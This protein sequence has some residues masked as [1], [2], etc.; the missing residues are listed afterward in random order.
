MSR[1]LD[2]RLFYYAAG[3]C[4]VWFAFGTADLFSQSGSSAAPHSPNPSMQVV[5]STNVNGVQ[6]L[7]VLDQNTRGLA[8]YH[9]DA[10]GNLQLRSVRTLVWDLRMEEFNAQA[11]TPSELKRIQP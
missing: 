4:L 3:A 9:V 6:Q 11:P 8:V 7:V 5:S 1:W 10:T 2:R